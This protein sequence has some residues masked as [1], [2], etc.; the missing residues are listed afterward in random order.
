MSCCRHGFRDFLGISVAN[1]LSNRNSGQVVPRGA[2][3][4]TAGRVDPTDRGWPQACSCTLMPDRH[5]LVVRRQRQLQR[6]GGIILQR[7]TRH[8]STGSNRGKLPSLPFHLALM[9]TSHLSHHSYRTSVP[10]PLPSTWFRKPLT[11]TDTVGGTCV[12]VCCCTPTGHL[13][14]LFKSMDPPLAQY[15]L[16]HARL[17]QIVKMRGHGIPGLVEDL[18]RQPRSF[19]IAHCSRRE[20]SS[21]KSSM[22]SPCC[23]YPNEGNSRSSAAERVSND[24]RFGVSAQRTIANRMACPRFETPQS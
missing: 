7:T 9:T 23:A 13:L 24:Y 16:S 12:Q 14:S 6:Q 20:D 1:V 3:Q 17:L 22:H 10:R 4:A 2:M 18:G 5:D 19:T 21:E 8:R 11:V 15:T